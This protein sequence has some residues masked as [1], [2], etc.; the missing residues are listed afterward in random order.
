M[1]DVL[2]QDD[3]LSPPD[4][5]SAATISTPSSLEKA[6]KELSLTPQER[7]LYERHLSNL[8]GPG[9]VNNPDGSRS[10]LFQATVEVDGKF[11][12]IPTVW[13]GS[14]LPEQDAIRQA[15]ELGWDNFP[16]Y[17]SEDAAEKRYEAMHKFMESDTAQYLGT[18]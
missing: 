2:A 4:V 15:G 3:V 9:G 1:P 13:N 16:S 10:T 7:G 6:D 5:L 8:T 18:K 12:V 14:M 11:Y 17:E